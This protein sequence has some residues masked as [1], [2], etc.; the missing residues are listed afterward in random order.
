VSTSAAC[1]RAL[2]LYDHLVPPGN[3]QVILGELPVGW[4][5]PTT[6]TV[7]RSALMET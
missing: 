2:D 6:W 3:A 5:M 4:S 7:P 1:H